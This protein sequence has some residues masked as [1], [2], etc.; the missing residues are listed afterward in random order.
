MMVMM[1]VVVIKELRQLNLPGRGVR[2]QPRVICFQSCHRIRNRIEKIPV[3]CRWGN[4]ASW[5]WCGSIR[6]ADGKRRRGA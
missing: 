1:M 6:R 5:G 2:R 4:L 3:G